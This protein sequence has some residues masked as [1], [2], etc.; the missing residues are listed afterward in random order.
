MAE[1]EVQYDM[2]V[3]TTPVPLRQSEWQAIG[4]IVREEI[5]NGM[6]EQMDVTGNP[7]PPLKPNTIASKQG[8]VMT[9]GKSKGLKQGPRTSAFP[10]KRLIDTGNMIE[11]AYPTATDSQVEI[12]LGP[13][14]S[15]IGSYQQNGIEPHKITASGKAL[16][17]ITTSGPTFAKSVQHPGTP[18]V[19][20]F[21]ISE[22]CANRI[23][24]YVDIQVDKWLAGTPNVPQ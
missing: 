22:R 5:K 10:T 7:Y 21:G 1:V 17:F 11:S 24:E 23:M 3:P 15:E 20:F 14:R 16:A 12:R 9:G 18:P 2:I 4:L 6:I 19:P 8:T 13:Q